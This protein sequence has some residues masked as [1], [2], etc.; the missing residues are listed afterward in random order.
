MKKNITLGFVSGL[1]LGVAFAHAE[2][3]ANETTQNG[4]ETKFDYYKTRESKGNS[5][6]TANEI[7]VAEEPAKIKTEEGAALALA[8][9]PASQAAS[10]ADLKNV[11]LDV[12][13]V[14]ELPREEDVF[15]VAN[16]QSKQAEVTQLIIQKKTTKPKS[17]TEKT[18]AQ[19][20][21]A[22]TKKVARYKSQIVKKIR[23][24]IVR[25]PDIPRHARADFEVTLQPGGIVS[26]AVLVKPSGY[27]AYDSAV[28]R[29]IKKAEPLPVPR[30]A[31]LFDMFRELRISFSP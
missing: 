17:Q 11:V 9:Q 13:K 29:A 16:E 5:Q 12:V 3:S 25:L 30:D 15:N 7:A 23:L 1:I 28:E 27:A 6:E 4:K 20:L 2:S 31:T 18:P 21:L 26:N 19:E 22:I 14:V 10:G 24:N 8:V